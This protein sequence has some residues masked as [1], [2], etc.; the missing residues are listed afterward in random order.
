M[1]QVPND[2]NYPYHSHY[3]H[4]DVCDRNNSLPTGATIII[5]VEHLEF[6]LLFLILSSHQDVCDRNDCLHT[7]TTIIIVVNHF[8][9]KFL[10]LILSPS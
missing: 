6:K 3:S 9:F 4:Q 5:V 1:N 8:E 10:I 2:N 7:D